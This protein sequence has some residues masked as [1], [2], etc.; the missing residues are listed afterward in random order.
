MPD[1]DNVNT[2]AGFMSA[3]ATAVGRELTDE[4][5]SAVKETSHSTAS[6]LTLSS[7]ESPPAPVEEIPSPAAEE[8]ETAPREEEEE[9]DPREKQLKD[10]QAMIGKQGQEIGELRK[11]L[12]ESKEQIAR[13]E[14]FAASF[15]QEDEPSFDPAMYDRV[16]HIAEERGGRE[17]VQLAAQ[18]GDV[19]LIDHA[20][21]RWLDEEEDPDAMKYAIRWEAWKANNLVDEDESEEEEE[22]E[23]PAATI[24]P[25]IQALAIRERQQTVLGNLR[26][27]TGAE[28]FDAIVPHVKTALEALPESLQQALGA[29]MMGDEGQIKEAFSAILKLAEPF[30][31]AEAT[32]VV[33]EERK[34]AKQAAQVHTGS[35][36]ETKKPAGTGVT[37]DSTS[38]E[39][40]E[41]LHAEILK[42][43]STSVMDNIEWKK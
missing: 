6:G 10:S 37:K 12:Q 25:E 30:S 18:T 28:K 36:G 8:E 38:E 16:D 1:K 4:E 17:A 32:R 33:G 26:E 42:A 27:E 31:T 14:G 15:E 39:K 23:P 40:R 3:L 43:P 13:L 34:T 21:E 19:N 7:E 9:S 5:L 35:R 22:P 29:K 20:V 2:A 11:A 41:W 24:P